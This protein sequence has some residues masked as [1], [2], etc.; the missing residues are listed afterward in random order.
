MT[1]S[2]EHQTMTLEREPRPRATRR[3]PNAAQVLRS[4]LWIV[5]PVVMAAAVFTRH[6]HTYFFFDE[7]SEINRA[8]FHTS[9]LSEAFQPAVG[10]LDLVSYVAYVAQIRW[11][12]IGDHT[13]VFAVFCLSLLALHLTLAAVLRAL[14]LPDAVAVVAAAVVTYFGPGSQNMVF[15]V[16]LGPNFAM[17]LCF[18]AGLL[19]LRWR[20]GPLSATAVSAALVLAIAAD[21]ANA[22]IGL[23]FVAVLI[24]FRWRHRLGLAALALPMLGHA[25]WLLRTR[26]SAGPEVPVGLGQQVRFAVR[27]MLRA[28]GGLAGGGQ[29]VGA[30]GLAAAAALLILALRRRSLSG[31]SVVALAAG[32]AAAITATATITNTRA[33]LIGDDFYNFNRHIQTVAVYMLVALLPFIF[34]ALRPARPTAQQAASAI[35][36]LVLIAVFAANLRPL[37][38]YRDLFEHSNQRTKAQ[39]AQS[40]AVLKHGCPTGLTENL[41]ARPLGDLD[42]QLDVA[43]LDALRL[44]GQ[45]NLPTPHTIEPEIQNTICAPSPASNKPR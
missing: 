19:V 45:A 10:H 36:V 34:Q 40:I 3:G 38:D 7:W 23:V 12:G 28:V 15:A 9:H 13:F 26:A 6:T 43:L 29:L 16:Q 39:V 35:A 5:V 30:I 21:S 42:P 27:L 8:S 33:G 17:A 25:A 4:A 14:D 24:G 11:F 2:T 41:H 18:L 22:A 1:R 20:L 31:K 32:G 44:R 37:H